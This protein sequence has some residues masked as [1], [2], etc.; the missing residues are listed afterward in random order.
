MRLVVVVAG[1]ARTMEVEVVEEG[2][3]N[4]LAAAGTMG[5]TAMTGGVMGAHQTA[6]SALV[7]CLEE[8]QSALAVAGTMQQTA[9]TGGI[10]EANQTAM[11]A[12]V[13]GLEVGVNLL[14]LHLCHQ[15]LGHQ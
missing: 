3:Q 12:L 7:C 15:L 11:F 9:L 6:T 13:H 4:A 2:H 10:M 5:Q 14:L 1:V 8:H